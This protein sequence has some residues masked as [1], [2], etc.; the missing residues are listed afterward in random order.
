VPLI[1]SDRQAAC[2]ISQNITYALCHVRDKLMEMTH[3]KCNGL[4]ISFDFD[5]AFDRVSHHFLLDLFAKLNINIQFIAL[6]THMLDNMFSRILINGHLSEE[7]KIQSSV[8]QG[9]PLSMLFFVIYLDVLLQKIS[10][11]TLS[12][13][14]TTN[15]VI[16]YADDITVLVNSREK[17]EE[18]R[19]IFQQFEAVSGARV[20][21]NKTMAIKIGTIQEPP[22]LQIKEQIKTLGI[23]FEANLKKAA[24]SNWNL[25]VNKV[26]QMVW[27]HSSRNLNVL[28]K[29]I[30]CNTFI[31]SK[32][33]FLAA[34]FPA[35]NQ[36]LAR[37]TSAVGM[38]IW[39]GHALR[40]AF[41]QL[42]L[43]VNRGGQN[44]QS[45]TIKAKALFLA[46]F[47]RHS[48]SNPFL[49]T[50]LSFENPPHTVSFPNI[51][52]L[53]YAL[54]EICYISSNLIPEIRPKILYQFFLGN[55]PN[56]P[57]RNPNINWIAVWKNISK[58]FLNSSSRAIW[59]KLINNKLALKD[60]LFNQG[61]IASPLCP[62]CD[63]FNETIHHKYAVCEETRNMWSYI[64]N[65][66]HDRTRRRLTFD[67][68]AF[69]VLNGLR[70][71][72]KKFVTKIFAIY[73]NYIEET[74]PGHRQLATL[75]M[76]IENEANVL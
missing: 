51:F 15:T 46:N 41:N 54:S 12:S 25:T 50:F 69:P 61:R 20:N 43:P 42:I 64:Q 7:F 26:R 75:K 14:N 45:P 71:V 23:I 6:M 17:A 3:K 27:L 31:L 2:N 1:V 38:F 19:S 72:D 33:W 29:I 76:V 30:L 55:I 10:N 9:D 5:H 62:A 53:K 24:N 34:I 52:Y 73:L 36:M 13:A 66:I 70:S 56:P 63:Q 4:M 40:I 58:K 35:T 16:A 67:D 8:R 37:A 28:Q 39:R 74:V 65:I 47:L 21:Y 44:L 57:S 59:Y 32:L 49:Q 18:V 22:W 60:I 11:V 48:S 68:I